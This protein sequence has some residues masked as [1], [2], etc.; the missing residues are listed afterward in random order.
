MAN[1]RK[2]KRSDRKSKYKK[3]TYKRRRKTVKRRSVIGGF[4]TKWIAKLK[5]SQHFTLNPGA[6]LGA[7]QVFRA[8]S[9]FDPDVTGIGHQPSNF[10]RFMLNYDRFT[11]L[12]SKCL[13][14][15]V[16]NVNASIEPGTM[17]LH[18]SQD[19]TDIATAHASGGINNILEQ[20]RLAYN[21]RQVGIINDGGPWI[22][23]KNFSA[24]KFFSTKALNTNTY[25]GTAGANPQEQAF[26]ECAF[27][28][29]DD[30]N[31]PGSHH[32]RVDITY[33]VMFS[34]PKLADAS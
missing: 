34:E 5:Y 14:H 19:G 11:V 28:S 33:I 4:P 31:D 15:E 10:D 6:G 16:Q 25:S 1:T 12:G 26:Y 29:N 23:R 21:A 17:V 3:K 24:K 9:C 13:F 2:R 20:P 22:I 8:N 32:F 27:V 18:L 30:A 7:V